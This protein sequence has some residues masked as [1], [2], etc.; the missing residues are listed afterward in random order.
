[1]A[2]LAASARKATL[3]LKCG[4]TTSDFQT[5]WLL[6]L[7]AF[8]AFFILSSLFGGPCFLVAQVNRKNKHKKT[9]TKHHPK[10][11]DR[12]HRKPEPEPELS[13]KF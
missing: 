12:A 9:K 10:A 2:M 1:M 7:E 5:M 4:Q 8:G 13:A 3:L 11:I 6:A